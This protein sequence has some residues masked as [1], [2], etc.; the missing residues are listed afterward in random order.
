[1]KLL[2]S[3]ARALYFTTL[4]LLPFSRPAA[5]ANSYC[6]GCEAAIVGVAVGIGA[7][8]GVGIYFIHR[9]H[10]SL[11]GCVRQTDH[12]L[13][14]IAKDG[15]NYELLNA[16]SEVKARERLSLRGHKTKSGSGRTF[17]VDHVSRDY[18]L[19]SP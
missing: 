8:I 10:T 15:N 16:P 12:G 4:I 14:M 13:S 11:S 5:A 6:D 1:M 18:G 19:C 7:G 3:R 2:S 17:R 9:S